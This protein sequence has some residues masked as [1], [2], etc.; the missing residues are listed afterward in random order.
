MSR[1]RI[2]LLGGSALVVLTLFGGGVL[3]KVAPADGTYR[4]VILFSEV[5]SLVLDNYVDPVDSDRLLKGALDGMMG[6]I[7]AQGAYLSA[8]EVARWKESKS[9]GTADP[10][11]TVV[12][13]FGTLQIVAVA[14]RSP[15]EGAGLGAG[16]QIRRIDNISLRNA[17]MEQALRALRGD[18]GSTVRLSILH[19]RESFKREEVSVRRAERTDSPHRFE[20]RGGIGLLTVRDLRRVAPESMAADLKGAKER[21]V[22]KLLIDLRN[23]A[24]GSPRDAAALAGL[25]STGDLLVLKDR[26]GRAVETV[27]SPG[28]GNAWSGPVGVL[29]NGGT[30][31]GAEAVALLLQSRRRAT[32]YGEPTYGLGAEPKLFELP[33]G[34]GLLVSSLSW[35]AVGGRGWNGDGVAPDKVLRP[36]GRPD[37]AD[38]E[39]LKRA[40]E[41]LGAAPPA[42][43]ARKAA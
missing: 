4:Q 13:A 12:K 5:F 39:L 29:V 32:V 8:A 43:P 21:G 22:E 41:E 38:E 17:S 35:E 33:D 14:P 1:S 40:L 20:I 11:I 36:V 7:D 23:V 6:G 9:A 10:G 27:R 15:A 18:A 25:F 37:S 30:A 16:D 31:G 26:G 42:E 2:A 3:A 24:D 34:S 19:T 28:A